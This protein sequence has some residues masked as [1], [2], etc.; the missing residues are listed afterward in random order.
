MLLAVLLSGTMALSSCKHS[1]KNELH[2]QLDSRLARATSVG[3]GGGGMKR[4]GNEMKS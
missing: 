4:V 2:L 3:A 1:A